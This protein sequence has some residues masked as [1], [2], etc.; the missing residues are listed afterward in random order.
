MSD[1]RSAKALDQKIG[2]RIRTRRLE[3]GMSQER[4]AELLGVTFQQVQ[5]YEKGVNRTAA[6]RL[7]DISK[8]LDMP[9]ALFFETGKQMS[10]AA[11]S[12]LDTNQGAKLLSLF[13]SVKSI[14]LRRRI[15]DLV[16]AMVEE[17]SPKR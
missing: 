17:E 12:A 6:S 14:K 13:G 1:E 3:I 7:Y 2:L 5:K 11:I 4:L 9:V 8:A 16:A 15:L 10:D